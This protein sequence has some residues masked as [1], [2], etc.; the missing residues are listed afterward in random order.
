MIPGARIA[1]AG[2][3]SERV[4]NRAFLLFTC[5]ALL[6]RDQTGARCGPWTVARVG[7]AIR[8]WQD[9]HRIVSVSWASTRRRAWGK[10]RPGG[11]GCPIGVG[12]GG[13][14]FPHRIAPDQAHQGQVSMQPRPGAALVVAQPQFLLAVL[15]K[16]LDRPAPMRQPQLVGQAPRVQPPGEVPFRVTRLARQ[17]AF[18]EQPAHRPGDVSVGAMDPHPT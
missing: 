6:W 18:P 9:G 8:P 17:G 3:E 1:S 10:L 11:K 4:Y 12:S 7:T 15:M 16:S 13:G 2:A 14:G 5:L